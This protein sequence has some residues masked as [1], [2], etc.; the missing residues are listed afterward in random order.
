MSVLHFPVRME[1]PALTTLVITPANVWLHLKV[2][3]TQGEGKVNI[4]NSRK[5]FCHLSELISLFRAV[6]L[7]LY[8]LKASFKSDQPI[9]T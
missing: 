3:N 6:L 2:M 8:F 1:A 7:G 4:I 5:H 9:S